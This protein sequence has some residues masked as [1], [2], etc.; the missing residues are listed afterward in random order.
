MDSCPISVHKIHHWHQ[1]SCFS[2]ATNIKIY[3][4]LEIEGEIDKSRTSTGFLMIC[5]IS[6]TDLLSSASSEYLPHNDLGYQYGPWNSAVSPEA[7]QIIVITM[8]S[9]RN[10]KNRLY[11]VTGDSIPLVWPCLKPLVY[12]KNENGHKNVYKWQNTYHECGRIIHNWHQ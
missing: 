12:W 11:L 4:L 9:I 6:A 3:C 7:V 10:I 8:I 5:R 1:Y 2:Q